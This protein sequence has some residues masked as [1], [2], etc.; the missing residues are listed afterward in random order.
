MDI[1]FRDKICNFTKVKTFNL[2]SGKIKSC[3]TVSLIFLRSVNKHMDRSDLADFVSLD[4]QTTFHKVLKQM[5][6]SKQSNH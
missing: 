2:T 5:H 6:F 3:L 4:F 1:D